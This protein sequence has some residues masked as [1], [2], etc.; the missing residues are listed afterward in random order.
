[1]AERLQLILIVFA[2]L[3]GVASALF[4]VAVSAVVPRLATGPLVVLAAA[5][6]EILQRLALGPCRF[7]N[8]RHREDPGCSMGSDW[9]R[10]PL[11]RQ[12]LEEVE[13]MA[14]LSSRLA[15]PSRRR[16]SRRQTS[17]GIS[18]PGQEDSDPDHP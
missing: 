15:T 4:G 7:R 5:F 14:A 2:V 12:C 8:C 17:Q 13:A 9:P 6:P 16:T 18:R 3:F 1:M 11:Y 10:F